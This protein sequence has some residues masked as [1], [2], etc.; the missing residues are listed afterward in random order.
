MNTAQL[1][2]FLSL[3]ET[4]N[5]SKSAEKLIV[6]QST[7]SKRIQDLEK[8]VGQELFVRERAGIELTRAGKA[9]LEYVE[10]IVNL[11]EKAFLQINRTSQYSGYLILGTVYAYYDL[12]LSKQLSRFMTLHPEISIRVKFGH[13]GL[14]LSEVGR[15]QIDIAFTHHPFQHPEYICKSLGDDDVILVTD[16]EN[17]EHGSGISYTRIKELPL[18]SSNFLYTTT[19]SWLFPRDQQFQLEVDIASCTLPLLRGQKWYTLLARKLVERQLASGEL[20]EVPVLDGNI[21]PVQY[22]LVYRK[23]SARQTAVREWLELLEE[24]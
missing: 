17:R 13:S 12:Y 15:G 18:L 5:F 24:A 20:R 7:V 22:Y 11:E 23:E 9:L 3:A 19:Q 21:P 1:K 8:E 4:R 6:S 10:Q 2:T 14:M 16:A